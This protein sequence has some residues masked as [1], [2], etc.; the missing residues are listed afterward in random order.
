MRGELKDAFLEKG[1]GLGRTYNQIIPTLRIDHMFYDPTVL[2]PIGF[3]CEFTS[4]SDHNPV[5]VNFEIIP[6]AAN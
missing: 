4:L 3:N 1:R 5:I 2:K 6:K